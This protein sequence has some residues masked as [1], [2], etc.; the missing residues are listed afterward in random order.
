MEHNYV[1]PN[2]KKSRVVQT[3]LPQLIIKAIIKHFKVLRGLFNKVTFRIIN[4]TYCF[5]LWDRA[6]REP[7]P[8]L[9]LESVVSRST[10]GSGFC[11]S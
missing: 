5:R 6:N 1:G 2:L 4:G 10:S 11:Y 7:Q 8:E 3:Y 9:L